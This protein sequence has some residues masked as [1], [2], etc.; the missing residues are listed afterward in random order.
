MNELEIKTQNAEV[1]NNELDTT[2]HYIDTIA[3]MKK[4]S[5]KRDEYDK[6]RSENRR[7]L[8]A[9]ASGKEI[10][11]PKE[12]KLDVNEL[13]KKLFGKNADL[14]NIDYVDTALKL[15]NA[16]IERG[17]RDPFLPT[18]S[19]VSETADMYEKAQNV[20]DLLQDCVDFAD[21]DSGVFT[22]RYQSMV[23]DTVLPGRGRK[24]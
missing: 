21:G 8:D 12:E 9:L 2:Q 6:L 11:M 16:L 7:L 14:S 1:N 23:K 13:R 3:E 10:E 18:G 4:N 15:R 19:H 20:A 22:A 17:E 24:R 5:V